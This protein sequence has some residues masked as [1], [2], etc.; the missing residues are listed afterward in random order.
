MTFWGSIE[1]YAT[2]EGVTKWYF[3]NYADNEENFRVRM[4]EI[5]NIHDYFMI[6]LVVG[7]EINDKT[8]DFIVD[9]RDILENY[10]QM[11]YHSHINM[12]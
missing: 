5:M 10:G 8:P 2:G 6:G 7:T 11:Q 3:I 1:Y 12:S 9:H 4:Q